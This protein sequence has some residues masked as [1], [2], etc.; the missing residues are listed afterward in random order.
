MAGEELDDTC[1]VEKIQRRR[2][3]MF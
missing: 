1:V 2:G 3:W